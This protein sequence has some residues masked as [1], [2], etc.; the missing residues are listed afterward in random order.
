MQNCLN[1]MAFDIQDL[2]REYPVV[3]VILGMFVITGILSTLFGL[4]CNK[5]I[6]CSTI[7]V[8]ALIEVGVLI[9]VVSLF[10]IIA[11]YIV[12]YIL[13]WMF[14]SPPIHPHSLTGAP[15]RQAFPVD[16]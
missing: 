5:Y 15:R 11:P 8:I 7:D 3:Y 14:Y 2:S 9:L 16:V 4:I 12:R 1:D 6:G 10:Y 13:N